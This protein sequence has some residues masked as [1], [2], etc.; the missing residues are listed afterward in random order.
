MATQRTRI[1]I[2]QRL[3]RCSVITSVRNVI[4]LVFVDLL[5]GSFIFHTWRHHTRSKFLLCALFSR[6]VLNLPQHFVDLMTEVCRPIRYE[7]FTRF[8]H[9]KL[10]LHDA[11]PN[12]CLISCLF[13]PFTDIGT[14]HHRARRG[15]RVQVCGVDRPCSV[16][17]LQGHSQG[18]FQ[19]YTFLLVMLLLTDGLGY[20]L[21]LCL[22][23]TFMLIN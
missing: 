13:L 1:S 10:M 18:L 12:D 20:I 21:C 16:I 19:Y 15:W 8:G 6:V 5:K 17:R 2:L 4:Q 23:L 9:R 11:K 22:I 7:W 14:G 3:Q